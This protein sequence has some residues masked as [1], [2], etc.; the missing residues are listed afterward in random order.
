[1]P[2]SRIAAIAAE[3]GHTVKVSEKG[4]HVGG[5]L[6]AAAKGPWGDEEFQR[7]IDYLETRAKKFGATIELN[8]A[9]S[10]EDVK[11][12]DADVVIVATGAQPGL[13]VKGADRPNV[14]SCLDVF[15]E[16]VPVGKRVVILGD[17]GAAIATALLLLDRGH[18]VTM[19]GRA[20]KPGQDVNPSYIWRYM[21]KLKDEHAVVLKSALVREITERGV[22]ID[23][24]EGEQL[25]EADTVVM[26]YMQAEQELANAKKPTYVIGDAISPRRAAGAILDGY[27]MGMRL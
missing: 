2:S 21:L 23:T 25:L 11:K 12:A 13:D 10:R 16:K 8:T 1:V 27:R 15:H 14:V 5:Q 24:P 22:L 3:K 6:A 19:A 7:L 17:S 4:D 18:E 20:K 9:V 26:A